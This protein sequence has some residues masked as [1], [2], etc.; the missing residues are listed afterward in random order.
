[1]AAASSHGDEAVCGLR[2]TKAVARLLIRG[3]GGLGLE[4][5]GTSTVLSQRDTPTLLPITVAVY[6]RTVATIVA[7]AS[8]G[9][10]SRIA[11]GTSPSLHG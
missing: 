5:D 2:T 7:N 9:I 3:R 1:M 4:G 10:C 6:L 11:G 8:V